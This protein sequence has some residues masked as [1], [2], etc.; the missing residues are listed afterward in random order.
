MPSGY[1][2]ATLPTE[3]AHVL[4]P[5]KKRIFLNL[6]SW[7]DQKHSEKWYQNGIPGVQLLKMVPFFQRATVPLGHR[8]IEIVPRVP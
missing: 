4:S 3:L 5:K 1:C 6:G 8:G 2:Y 7:P